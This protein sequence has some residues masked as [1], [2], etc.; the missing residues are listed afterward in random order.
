MSKTESAMKKAELAE[1]Q[2][3]QLVHERDSKWKKQKEIRTKQMIAEARNVTDP[4]HLR[5][6]LRQAKKRKRKKS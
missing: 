4:K 5:K 1:R 6:K 2:L 3:Q